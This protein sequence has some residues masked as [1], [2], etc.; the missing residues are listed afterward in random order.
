MMIGAL[1]NGIV[2]DMPQARPIPEAGLTRGTVPLLH[3]LNLT[4]V[5]EESLQGL[6]NVGRVLHEHFVT[7]SL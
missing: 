2:E 3:E 1:L 4:P 7:K 5:A 6:C